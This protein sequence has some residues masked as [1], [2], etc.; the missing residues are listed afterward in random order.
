MVPGNFNNY[1]R[2]CSSLGKRQAVLINGVP[3]LQQH[4]SKLHHIVS[5]ILEAVK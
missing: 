5:T 3:G 1:T 2:A 4:M